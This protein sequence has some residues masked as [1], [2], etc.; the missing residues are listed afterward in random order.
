MKKFVACLLVIAI[1]IFP[2]VRDLVSKAVPQTVIK[3]PPKH[4]AYKTKWGVIQDTTYGPGLVVQIPLT[5]NLG[6][7]VV[8]KNVEPRNYK[9]DLDVRTKRGY[10]IKL[11]VSVVC[12]PNW[13]RLHKMVM[14]GIDDYD[15]YEQKIIRDKVQS[16]MA[17]LCGLTDIWS[18][19]GG[20]EKMMLDATDYIVNDQLIA[21]GYV[22][23]RGVR[24]LGYNADDDF[25]KLLKQEMLA[26]QE[27]SI[28]E[29]KA[30]KAAIETKRVKEEAIQNYER[31]ASTVK[32]EGLKFQIQAE[33]LRDNPFVAQ[34]ELAKA[35]Q[36]W[37]GKIP[38]LPE[39]LTIMKTANA[40]GMPLL[41]IWPSMKIGK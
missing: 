6:N 4:A 5:E 20:Y 16:T 22:S 18:L 21:D 28:E 11:Q 41:P 7:M 32:A 13:M 10:K 39:T 36:K 25:E 27:L 2:W 34:Y 23:V 29:L 30:Q 17:A 33:A 35:I 19:V 37:N 38:D 24:L 1:C 8:V 26:A 14:A 3:V 9:Y 12:Q 40:E 15:V 31:L